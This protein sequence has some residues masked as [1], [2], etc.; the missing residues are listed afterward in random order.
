MEIK[1]TNL[2]IFLGLV[3][4]IVV[5]LAV[6][7]DYCDGIDNKILPHPELCT[8]FVF[9]LMESPYVSQCDPPKEVF[10]EELGECVAG[11]FCIYFGKILIKWKIIIFTLIKGDPDSCEVFT[12]TTLSTSTTTT[13]SYSSTTSSN[14]PDDLCIGINNAVF[15]HPDNCTLYILCIYEAPN[16]MKCDQN[17]I[18]YNG[19][20]VEG[21]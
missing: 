18:F 1:I 8:H 7:V 9:C 5:G 19:A 6:P 12:T 10:D 15:P 14:N 20:C 2:I 3:P 21:E 11:K 13:L 16:I 4:F 17:K